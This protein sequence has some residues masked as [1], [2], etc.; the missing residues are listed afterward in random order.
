MTWVDIVRAIFEV[1]AIAF[2][3]FPLIK[4]LFKTKGKLVEFV[5]KIFSSV[6]EAEKLYDKG[7]E[8]L[9]YVKLCIEAWCVDNKIDFK[10]KDIEKLIELTV[11]LANLI[12]R[13]LTKKN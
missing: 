2:L 4:Y 5:T 13:F 12:K 11:A 3:L 7:E 1:L 9:D 6:A 8:K 10:A